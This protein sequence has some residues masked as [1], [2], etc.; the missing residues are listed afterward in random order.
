MSDLNLPPLICLTA[1]GCL[2]H[3]GKVL[4]IKHKK[5]GIWLSPGGHLEANELPHQAAE[6]E[7]WEETGIKVRA[8]A[9]GFMPPD[10]RTEYLP[11]PIASNLHWIS[12]ENYQHRTAGAERSA[13][14]AKNWGKGCEQ[15]F[16]MMYLVEPVAGVTFAQNQ[17]ETDGIG[18]FGPD[19]IAELETP[20]N[21]KLELK[22]AFRLS[23]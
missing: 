15:H 22:E 20:A 16:G 6:R 11:N 4:L 2:I 8:K 18:W 1:C 5:L 17:E 13:Q 23:E 9:W 10:E 7:F 21:I 19:E 3:Q 14:T 12:R